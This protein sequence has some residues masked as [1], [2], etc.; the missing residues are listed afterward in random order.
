MSPKENTPPEENEI[1]E[2]PSESSVAG[3]ESDLDEMDEMDLDEMD[4]DEMD[5]LDGEEG[6]DLSNFLVTE[7][8]ETVA[9]SLAGI[10]E[11]LQDLVGHIST[12]NKI[13]IKMLSKLS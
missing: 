7:D 13:L 4:L 6:I 12:T 8:G 10:G 5:A 2:I 1:E 9:E 3:D 11:S